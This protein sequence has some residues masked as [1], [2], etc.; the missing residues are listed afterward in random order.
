[1]VVIL[2]PVASRTDTLNERTALPSTCT[3]QAPQCAAPQANLVPVSPICSRIAHR[4]GMSG[5]ASIWR[6]LPLTF[7][8]KVAISGFQ[9][10]HGEAGAVEVSREGSLLLQRYV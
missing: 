10:W 4:S 3:V 1:M 8:A 9:P 2:L 6:V 7:S 5:G